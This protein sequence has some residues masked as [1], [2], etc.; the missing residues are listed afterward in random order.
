MTRHIT[1]TGIKS[2][3]S[4]QKMGITEGMSFGMASMGMGTVTERD[5]LLCKQ[6]T[7]FHPD[8]FLQ[9]PQC[10][11]VA[12]CIHYCTMVQELKKQNNWCFPKCCNNAFL[13]AHSYS[14]ISTP[15]IKCGLIIQPVSQCN[16]G[17]VSLRISY[18][19]TIQPGPCIQQ[20][21]PHWTTEG[22]F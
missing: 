18:T 17:A 13:H 3:F 9:V 8:D 12:V 6:A 5:Y 16:P 4:K 22:E 2:S 10:Y 7:E 20:L 11:A 19:S 14:V 21:P 15:A 1:L